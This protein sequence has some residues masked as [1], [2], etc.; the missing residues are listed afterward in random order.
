MRL[1]FSV[2]YLHFT[3][4]KIQSS[5]VGGCE[6]I[7]GE[8]LDGEGDGEATAAAGSKRDTARRRRG[9]LRAGEKRAWRNKHASANTA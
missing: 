6:G 5:L 2:A 9:Q 7:G 8:V 4:A 3:E 1:C